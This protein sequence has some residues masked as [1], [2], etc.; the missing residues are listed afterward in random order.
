MDLTSLARRPAGLGWAFLGRMPGGLFAWRHEATRTQV[1]SAVKLPPR[2]WRR[3]DLNGPEGLHSQTGEALGPCWI[4]MGYRQK[5]GYGHWSVGGRTDGTRRMVVPHRSA[6]EA[7]VGP[8]PKN[9]PHLDHLCRVRHCV[10]PRH[11]EPVTNRV[12]CQRG[13]AGKVNGAR[14]AAKTHCAQGHAYTPENTRVGVTTKGGPYRKCRTCLRIRDREYYLRKRVRP[15]PL[16]NAHARQ[17][18]AGAR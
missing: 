13:V 2:F 3:V 5:T 4:W 9:R 7:L 6:Y 10:N 15:C 18:R 17:L 8:I 12:N 1:V 16:H 11:L 14:E